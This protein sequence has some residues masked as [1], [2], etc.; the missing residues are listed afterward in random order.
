[1]CPSVRQ[2]TKSFSDLHLIW[3]VGR[4][5]PRMRTLVTSTRSKVKVKITELVKFQIIHYSRSISFP[6]FAC[7][8]K[9]MVSSDSIRPCLQVSEPDFRTAFQESYHDSSNFA[10]SRYFTKFK[11]PYFGSAWGY[12][13]MVGQAGSSTYIVHADMTLTRSKFKIIVTGLINFRKLQKIALF[14]VYLLRHF[15]VELKTHD[16]Y[17]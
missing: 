6:I 1:M 9:L 7:S 12:S 5:R 2:S 3:C 15:R 17:W 11:L 16:W 4:P 10:E 13:Q 8:S 14:Y